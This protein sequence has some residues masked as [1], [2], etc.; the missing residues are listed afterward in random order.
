L[1]LGEDEGHLPPPSC[2]DCSTRPLR[3]RL[4]PA[5]TKERGLRLFVFGAMTWLIASA[6]PYQER[7]SASLFIQLQRG[8]RLQAASS[9]DFTSSPPPS[10]ARHLLRP[11]NFVGPR[12]LRPKAKTTAPLPAC[13]STAPPPAREAA[14]Y[15]RPSIARPLRPMRRP[16]SSAFGGPTSS[17]QPVARPPSAHPRTI[18]MLSTSGISSAFR[19]NTGAGAEPEIER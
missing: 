10:S 5:F 18:S 6:S 2:F 8:L 17:A 19:K 13:F 3:H 14:P 9:V 7:P 11:G 1:A 15:L 12:I 4:R 16:T